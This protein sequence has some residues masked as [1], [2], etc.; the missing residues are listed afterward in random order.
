MGHLKSNMYWKR[1]H[2]GKGRLDCIILIH[3][4]PSNQ[5]PFI[6]DSIR[7]DVSVS[8]V[9]VSLLFIFKSILNYYKEDPLPCPFPR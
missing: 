4:F 9:R 5:D 7:K 3:N 8:W 1:D 6:V 2:E